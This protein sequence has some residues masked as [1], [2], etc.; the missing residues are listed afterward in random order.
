MVKGQW[1]WSMF[2]IVDGRGAIRAQLLLFRSSQMK[3]MSFRWNIDHGAGL[4]ERAGMNRT[5]LSMGKPWQLRWERI[6]P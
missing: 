1:Q 2:T 4:I 5:G 3:N 6:L